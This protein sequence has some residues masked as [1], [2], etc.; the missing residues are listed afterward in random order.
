MSQPSDGIKVVDAEPVQQMNAPNTNAL[1][2]NAI[3]NNTLD[4][5]AQLGSRI[6]PFAQRLNKGLGQVRQYAQEKLGTAESV[7]ELP[8]EYKALEKRLDALR[9]VQSNMLKVTRTFNNPSYDYPV[10]AQQALINITNKVTREIQQLTLNSAADRAAAQ[11]QASPEEP[12]TLLHGLSRVAAQGS[13]E[14]GPEDPLGT[15][16]FKYATIT[17]KVADARIKMDQTI[18]EQFNKPVQTTLNSSIEQANKARRNVQSIRLSLDACKDRYRSARPE[19]SEAA[20][21]EV[22][23][24]E[25]QFVAAVEESTNLMKAALDNPEFYRNL[26]DLVAT[27]LQYFK[28]AQDLLSDLAP[29]LDEIQVTQEALYRNSHA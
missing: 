22:E 11:Q 15:A 27:Q 10:Q 9:D 16:L 14:V 3:F 17:N 21:L 23:Q 28:D 4:G 2:P 1:N 18:V 19:K 13:Q 20:R 7:T 8:Q 12:K 29:E 25:D 6:N 26:S 5:F 24:A